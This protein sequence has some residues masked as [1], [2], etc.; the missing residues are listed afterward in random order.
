VRDLASGETRPIPFDEAVYSVGGGLNIEFATTT[1]RVDYSSLVTPPSTFEIDMATGERTLLKQQEII[2][3][4]DPSRYVSERIFATA[5]TA[6]RSRSPSS[7]CAR[8]PPV[9][10]RSDSMP[11]APTAATAS[12]PSPSTAWR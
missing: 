7:A 6:P 9:R 10:S 12:R 2:G 1:L 5:P 4:H 8:P 3:G 11:T